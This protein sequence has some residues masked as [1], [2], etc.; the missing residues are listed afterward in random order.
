MK[1]PHPSS[2]RGLSILEVL[3]VVTCLLVLA[4]IILP[5]VSFSRAKSTRIGCLN[6]LKN[7]GLALRIFSTDHGDRWPMDLSVTNGGTREWLADGNQLWRHWLTLSNE[8][9]TPELLLCPADKERQPSQPIFLS[10]KPLTWSQF[11]DNSHLSYFLG[12]NAREENPQTILGG[13]RNLTTNNV[14]VGPG[15]LL[16]KTNLVLGFTAE[17]HIGS[18]NGAGNI[19]LGDGSVQQVTSGRLREAWHDA[20]TSSGLSTN[21]WLVP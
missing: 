20:H 10:P 7:V 21:V 19:L 6:K 2:R 3:V 18:G 14:A 16:L 1:A 11:A 12:L 5:T 9:P 17:M 8:L 13:D 15:C 4:A